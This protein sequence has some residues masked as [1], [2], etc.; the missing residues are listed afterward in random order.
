MRHRTLRLLAVALATAIGLP[1]AHAAQSTD[2]ATVERVAADEV[3]IKWQ[4]RD[5]VDVFRVDRPDAGIAGA[6]LVSRDDRD[7][8]HRM[9]ADPLARTYFLLRNTRSGEVRAVAERIVPLEQAS[10]FRDLGGY[11]G[12]DGRRVRWG[13]IY[14]AGAQPLLT[15]A[16]VLRVQ[17]LGIGNIVDLR[18]DEERIVAPTRLDGIPY[19]AVGYSMAPILAALGQAQDKPTSVEQGMINLY[20]DMPTQIAPQ[21]RL[22]FKR[23]LAKQG[24][25]LFNCSAGQD[26]TGLAAALVLSA[27]GVDRAVIY[28]DYLLSTANRRTKW[29]LP[30]IPEGLASGNAIFAYFAKYQK[31]PKH[32]TPIPLVTADGTPFLAT[33]FQTIEEKWG[34]VD[35]YLQQEMGLSPDDIATLRATYLAE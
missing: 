16:D 4:G 23:L 8:V 9:A 28:K 18:S 24:A 31:D 35:N 20:R 6:Q 26:R 19:N 34:S 32:Q 5:P 30:V 21:L 15:D 11:T 22:L 17:A 14:R 25:T 7:G 33:A 1:G 29:E 2:T 3:A 13:M 12:V 27:L 10:N